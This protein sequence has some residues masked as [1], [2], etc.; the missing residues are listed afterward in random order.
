[1]RIGR[2]G[3]GCS[4]FI[5]FRPVSVGSGRIGTENEDL[6]TFDGTRPPSK[7]GREIGPQVPGIDDFRPAMNWGSRFWVVYE[8]GVSLFGPGTR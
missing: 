3:P 7:L 6:G 5:E 4:S 1:M 8:L 2:L